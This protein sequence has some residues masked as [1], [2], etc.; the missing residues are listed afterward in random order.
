MFELRTLGTVD[1]RAAPGSDVEAEA[2]ATKCVA[3]LAYL[4]VAGAGH[5]VRRDT[6]LGLLWPELGDSRARHALRQCLHR[7]RRGLAPEVIRAKGDEAL[8]TDPD[9]LWCDAAEFSR[10]VGRGE[11][12]SALELYGGP[13]MEG[14]H[15][16]GG[17]EFEHWLTEIRSRLNRDASR[18]AWTLAERGEHASDPEA[19]MRW[20]RRAADLA[21]Y[22]EER[23]RGWIRMLGRLGNRS[24][25]VLAYRRFARRLREDLDLEPS[26]E[27]RE[28][29]AALRA[30]REGRPAREARALAVLPFRDLSGGDGGRR[31]AD[32]LTE[33]VNTRVAAG[34]SIP[35]RS[36]ASSAGRPGSGR[37]LRDLGEELEVDLLVRGSVLSAGDPTRV[38]VQLL[39]VEPE[40]HL[41]AEDYEVVAGEA[42]EAP[43][44]RIARRA[45]GTILA[46]IGDEGEAPEP[47]PAPEDAAGP[48]GGMDPEALDEFLRGR[49]QL[50]RLRQD[51]LPAALRHLRRAT[52]LAP[53]SASASALLAQAYVAVGHF[54]LRAPGDAFPRARELAEHALEI[55]PASAEALT[56]LGLVLLLFD[57]D[58]IGADDTLRRA[59][60]VGRGTPKPHWARALCLCARHRCD[61]AGESL[62]RARALD[63]LSLPLALTEG[64]MRAEAGEPAEAAEVAHRILELEPRLAYG[65]WLLG[66]ARLIQGR[67]DEALRSLQRAARL[68]EACPMITASLG[69]ALVRQGREG[70]A[71]DLIE[72]LREARSSRYVPPLAVATLQA[73]L[74]DGEGCRES[75]VRALAER[76]SWVVFLDVWPYFRPVREAGWFR[77]IVDRMLGEAEPAGAP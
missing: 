61:E 30:G 9:V 2:A 49:Y 1:L 53:E 33:L 45:A 12:R 34:A 18:A 26:R 23:W 52:S 66:T 59:A 35:V 44:E 43:E 14:F 37:P 42:G 48:A 28:L 46:R 60:E 75:V 39:S 24:H 57:R 67:G 62:Q 13:F 15:L 29:V 7:I 5:A 71:R 65:H 40:R 3:L 36:A 64:W 4:A 32:V 6:L 11:Y 38:T 20:G 17:H 51:A 74:G 56:A 54:A 47:T 72:V 19:A 76:D 55:R 41:W 58:F 8:L 10:L 77:E 16:D 70:E 50:E 21:P 25:A 31:L 63:P 73:G 69:L 68:G 27:T 22:N